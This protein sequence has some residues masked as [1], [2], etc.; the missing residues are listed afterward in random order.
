[1]HA[2]YA[3]THV[4]EDAYVSARVAGFSQH[5]LGKLPDTQA[6]IIGRRTSLT[7]LAGEREVALPADRQQTGAGQ[8]G[9]GGS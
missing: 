7:V 9:P 6:A 8:D 2:G 4:L 5:D 3:D 1:M